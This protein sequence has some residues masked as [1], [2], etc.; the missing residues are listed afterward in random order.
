MYYFHFYH[1]TNDDELNEIDEPNKW[2]FDGE[3]SMHRNSD[4]NNVVSIITNEKKREHESM[5]LIAGTLILWQ[6]TWGDNDEPL[7]WVFVTIL[8]RLN[9]FHLN[10]CIQIYW[11]ITHNSS[12]SIASNVHCHTPSIAIHRNKRGKKNPF[13]FFVFNTHKKKI[14]EEIIIETSRTVMRMMMK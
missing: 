1:K 2:I 11:Q 8:D 3:H 9:L 6:C 14:K 5:N 12:I 4:V 13:Y 10:V 7:P